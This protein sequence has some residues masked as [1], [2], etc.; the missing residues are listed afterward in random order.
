MDYTVLE[1]KAGQNLKRLIKECN[2]TQEQFAFE[3][4][5]DLRTLN[6]YINEGLKKTYL[7]AE[8]A[9]YFCV[10]ITEFFKECTND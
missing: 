1:R 5:M 2:M 3:Y 10:A 7:I 9:D 4:G 8:F 6:R